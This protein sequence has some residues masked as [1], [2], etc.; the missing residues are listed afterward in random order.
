MVYQVCGI[1]TPARPLSQSFP[2]R[3]GQPLPHLAQYRCR[4]PRSFL[5]QRELSSRRRNMHMRG[6]HECRLYRRT[7]NLTLRPVV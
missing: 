7:P 2:L 4:F 6:D 5:D 1:S 3:E